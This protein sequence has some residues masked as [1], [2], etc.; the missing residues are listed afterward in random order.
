MTWTRRDIGRLAAG[1]GAL[2]ALPPVLAPGPA[3]GA[4]TKV[5]HGVSAFGDLKYPADFDHFDYADPDAPVGGTFST[6]A[7]GFTF[8]SLNQFI[9][10]GNA[11]FGLGVTRD[12]LMVS[13]DDEAD[14]LYGL[15]AK[16]IEY[17]EDR[18]WAAFELREEAR[19]SD[20]SPITAEDLVFTFET[21]RDKGHP[22]Y[23][24]LLA[25]VTGVT[26]EGPLRVRYDFHPQA[27][28]RDLP[29]TVA[30]LSIISKAWYQTHD[31]TQSSLE[32][33]LASGPYMVEKV[34][35]GRTIVYRRRDDYWGWHLPVNRGRWN[36]ERI[37]FEYFREPSAFFEAFKSGTFTFNE[38]FWSKRWAT[39]YDFPAIASGDIVREVI[40]DNRP[41]G[42]QG[43][44]FN[45]RRPQF[46]D[47]RV[48]KAISLGFDFEWSNS[49]LFYQL[50][51]RTDSFFE[52]GPM[53]AQGKPSPGE[54]AVLEPLADLLPPSVL[55]DPAYVPPVSDG[56][57]RNRRALRESSRLL[58]A[59]GW[60]V[61]DGMR[62][63]EKG[64]TL[65][66]VFLEAAGSA[67]DR[68]TIPY[69]K[70]LRKIGID[71]SRRAVDAAQYKQRVERFDFDI[72]VDRK[73]MSLTPG[74][75]LRDY[76]HS[77]SANS[78]GSE[79]YAGVANPAVDALI[80]SIER[81]TSREQ[82]THVVKA[83]DRVL[84]AMHIWVPQWH[85]GSHTLAYWDI[86]DRPEIK[87]KYA[88][89]VIDLWWIDRARHARLK[90]QVGD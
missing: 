38:E 82:L 83:L 55:D 65:S 48:R 46:S 31:F 59:A 4:G 26:A 6:G 33:P 1:A 29:M 43:Y 74:V 3:L 76:F 54:L 62:R 73:G 85:K 17:P 22:S 25:A 8:D 71:A 23:K 69:V 87:P 27:P 35:P 61:R 68:I 63:N 58:D 2:T 39:G 12:S 14:S 56:S 10:K 7:S 67:F 84:R 45:T 20:G 79:N 53:Q 32:P 70:N 36:F 89:G 16:S 21:L 86:Y 51:T 72:V 49:R 57:G 19:W 44:W 77:A 60:P 40:P 66:V 18:L 30:G 13:A 34:E 37:R 47:P 5:A 9:L 11:A 52:G 88:R 78:K 28:R 15:V 75:E 24:V 81:A 50:Y 80:D 64:E 42:S 90:N 41:S